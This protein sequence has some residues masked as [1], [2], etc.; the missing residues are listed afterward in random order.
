MYKNKHWKSNPKLVFLYDFSALSQTIIMMERVNVM[1][2]IN[3][4]MLEQFRKE[5]EEDKTQRAMRHAI[6]NNAIELC[7]SVQ[8]EMT[9]NQNHF[10]IDIKTMKASNQ[11]TSGRCWIFA[12][13]NVLREA[14]AK[15]LHITDIEL[16]QNYIAFYDK[17]EKIRSFLE[18]AVSMKD[19]SLD[20]RT[21]VWLLQNGIGDG[22]QWDMF[23][24]IIEKYG[25][26]P[27]A[28]MPESFQSSN[29]AVMNQLINTRLRKFAQE[30]RNLSALGK[31]DEIASLSQDVLHQMYNF[32]CTCF[33]VPPKQIQFS[34]VD[35]DGD[36]HH[37]S[38]MTPLQF[39]HEEIQVD[40][41]EYVSIIHAPTKDKPFHEMFQVKH[42]AYT[43]GFPI[44][45]LNLPLSEFKDAILRQLKDHQLVWFGSDCGK[46]ND[47]K[48]GF[49]DDHS[50]AYEDAFGIDFR[51]DKE[52]AMDMRDSAMNHAM[53]LSG[54][55]LI[56][57]KPV[58]WKIENSWGEECGHKGYFVASDSWFDRFVY[59]AVI[60]K[61]YLNQ[62]QHNDLEKVAKEL[63]P[64]DPM[65]TL[66]K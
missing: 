41:K 4:S 47:K 56:E 3:E 37:Q 21:Y 17:L 30:V 14:L 18:L 10:S 42:I 6:Y 9:K 40:V 49:W 54:V 59:Q 64:W 13:L 62:E 52:S 28:C 63:E 26:I 46:F 19:T 1:E 58:K 65:G 5:Y 33:G 8:E 39:Y 20:D 66:A 24:N 34:Y 29:T 35:K 53:V 51:M 48:G 36:V 57:E 12:G 45:Y 15:R 25:V 55:D 11:L 50:F 38:E 7:A 22:G 2:S 32:L 27:K 60:H 16:S 61:Q 44:R 23:V 31:E 43:D